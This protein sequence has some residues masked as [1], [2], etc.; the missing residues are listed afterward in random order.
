MKLASLALLWHPLAIL[1]GTAIACYIWARQ[2]I[3]VRR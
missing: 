2:R 3:P 1:V